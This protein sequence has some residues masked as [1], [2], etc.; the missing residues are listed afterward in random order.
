MYYIVALN[1]LGFF[2][3][4]S[5]FTI[6]YLNLNICKHSKVYTFNNM[7]IP[8]LESKEQRLIW[9]IVKEIYIRSGLCKLVVEYKLEMTCIKFSSLK[10]IQW[11]N[12]IE[13]FIQHPFPLS[14]MNISSLNQIRFEAS[15]EIGLHSFN[16]L[17]SS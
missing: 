1:V 8:C 14:L 12:F 10:S 15:F 7:Y 17:M 2:C 3:I 11:N 16:D 5:N 6:Y 13:K 9:S 4:F